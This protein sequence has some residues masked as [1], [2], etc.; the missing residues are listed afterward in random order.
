MTISLICKNETTVVDLA[1]LT[2]RQNSAD[3][4]EAP[5][6]SVTFLHH[7][8]SHHADFVLIIPLLMFLVVPLGYASLKFSVPALKKKLY[9]NG[10]IQYA[11]MNGIVPSFCL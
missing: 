8:G 6:A 2:K 3:V 9:V 7:R 10:M 1:L 5:S 4:S 11:F